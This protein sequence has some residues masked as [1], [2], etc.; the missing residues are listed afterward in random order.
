MLHKSAGEWR[1]SVVVRGVRVRAP[2]VLHHRS[3]CR[4]SQD[5]TIFHRS[6]PGSRFPSDSQTDLPLLASSAC[7][8]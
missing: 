6:L 4:L 1:P 3:H 2:V 8:F 7:S 5:L